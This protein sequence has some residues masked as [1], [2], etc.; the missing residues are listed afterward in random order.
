MTDEDLSFWGWGYASK[1]PNDDER[2]RLA[3]MAETYLG[4]PERTLLETPKL[5]D[6]TV[7]ASGIEPPFSFC[8]TDD[9]ERARHTYGKGSPRPRTRLPRRLLARTRCR[10]PSGERGGYRRTTLMGFVEPCGC[11]SVRWR[12]ERCRRC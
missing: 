12:Y 4:F 2:R 10:R 1:L 9:E 3:E 6:V 8:T 11:G 7:P 5:E